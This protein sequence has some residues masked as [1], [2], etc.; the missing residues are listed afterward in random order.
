MARFF[1]VNNSSSNGTLCMFTFK[2]LLKTAGWVV[3]ASGDGLAA[4]SATSDVVTTATPGAGGLN[5]LGWCRLQSPEGAGSREIVFQ[6]TNAVNYWW[7]VKYSRRAGFT[8]GS[9]NATTT[10]T[11]TDQR[12]LA[13]IS[14][15]SG[16]F[17]N[18][19]DTVPMRFHCMADS[20]APYGFYTYAYSVGA[21]VLLHL[22]VM[23]P[24]IPGSF[25]PLDTDP[26]IFTFAYTAGHFATIATGYATPG[27][28]GCFATFLD[29]LA[30]EGYV[31]VRAPLSDLCGGLPASPYSLKTETFP[32]LHFRAAAQAL[33]NGWK[34]AGSYFR[35]VGPILATSGDTLSV[36]TARDHIVVQSSYALPWDGSTPLL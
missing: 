10:P 7:W 20:T 11:A 36:S 18:N 5:H 23:D 25:D 16:D 26:V 4:Y 13:N 14:S 6:R 15:S 29:N 2:E 12:N 32:R 19:S 21:G 3:K 1:S 17:F 22:L 35:F 30:G 27:Q 34:G 28:P 33:P 24:C 9:P 31:A 8:G